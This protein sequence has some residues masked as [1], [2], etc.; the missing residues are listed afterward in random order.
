MSSGRLFGFVLGLTLVALFVIG[1]GGAPA[2]TPA[3]PTAPPPPTAIPPAPTSVPPTP[4]PTPVAAA[5]DST[6]T[7]EPSPPQGGLRPDAPEFACRYV[8]GRLQVP[9]HR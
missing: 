4:E 7:P 5:P 3:P 9:G 2:A 6:A 1:C 8:L